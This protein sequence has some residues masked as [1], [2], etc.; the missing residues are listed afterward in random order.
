MEYN[1]KE[2]KFKIIRNDKAYY[3][4]IL[5]LYKETSD[6]HKDLN[7]IENKY[8]TSVYGP[9]NIGYL[10]FD[11]DNVASYY[12]VFPINLTFNGIEYLA[13]QS[14][15]TLTHP[16]YQKKGL[17]TYLAK[18]SY[19]L[20]LQENVQ[21]VFGFPN[22]NSLPGFQ[23]NLNW[24]CHH[25]MQELTIPVNT[26]PI[27]ELVSKKDFLNKIYISWVANILNK[28]K[29]NPNEAA[30]EGFNTQVNLLRVKKDLNFFKYKRYSNATLISKNNFLIFLKV[31][32][33]LIIGDVAFFDKN[34]LAEFLNTIK[35]LAR[36]LLVFKIKFYLS[37]NHWLF[38]YLKDAYTP[39]DNNYIGF[40]FI[41]QNVSIP[42]ED[43]LFSAADFDTF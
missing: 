20:A 7:F 22:K 12:G 9:I 15:D 29:V 28:I 1:F 18:V 38:D 30:L 26:L 6:Y 13:A 43:A 3:P 39:V 19:E 25:K 31:E 40:C 23:K 4:S 42:F 2:Q 33:H 41:N 17:F 5:K 14:G 24:V 27:A 35:Q 32:T 36:Q 8:N 21:L 16:N 10:A 37:S 11:Q 34:K